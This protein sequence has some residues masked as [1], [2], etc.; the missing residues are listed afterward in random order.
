MS[1][2]NLKKI[3]YNQL[4]FFRFKKFKNKY[5]LTNDVGDFLFLTKKEFENFLTNNLEK[6]KEPYLSL[7]EK[8]FL[9]NE[10]DLTEMI[11]KYRSKKAFLF[12]GPSLHIVVVT[13]RCN[14]RCIYC[15]ASAQDMS[16]KDLDMNQKTARQVVDKIFQTTSP[17]VAIEFQGGE[18]LIN[19]PVVKFIIEYAQKK[20]KQIKKDLQIRLVSNFSLMTEDKFKYLLS[21]KVNL[22]TSLDG[23]ERLHNKNRPMIK[24][25]SYKNVAKWVKKFYR[26]Y[27]DLRKKGYI[28]KMAGLLTI[29]RFSLPYWKEIINEY[30]KL[31]FDNISLR[32]LDPFGFSQ[33]SWQKIAYSAKDFINFYK[34]SLS[35]IIKLNLK[36][37]KFREE[38]A[39]V[40][41][42]KI[43]TN[44]D[45]NHLDFRSPCGAGI[46]QLA[47]NYNGDVYTCDEGRMMSM[48]GDES[49]RLGNIFKNSYQEIVTSP[50]VRTLCTASCLEGLPHCSNCV[51]KP[52][53]GVCPIYNYFAQGNIFGQMP[54]NQRC[55]I[56]QA[57]LD[58]LFEKLEN[59]QIKT[60]LETWPKKQI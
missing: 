39:T 27:P 15:H 28:Y 17:F 4:G 42:T 54:N 26:I 46:G 51:Y 56:N 58:F 25:N 32:V 38:I 7:K 41:L 10:L 34:K 21:K 59:P 5:L 43:L 12:G 60:I 19:W 1:S 29:S 13:L 24:G 2:L 40:F 9:K 45:P 36:G 11:E 8:N 47:Y 52:Y 49:F 37:K 14:H 53:C 31:G 55:Q 23:P 30:L 57:I 44:H 6:D 48:M 20:N 18:P 22:C 3:K 33:S 16:R 35:Y 50:I